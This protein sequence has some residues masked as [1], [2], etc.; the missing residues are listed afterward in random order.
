MH[1]FSIFFKKFNKLPFI[2]SRLD[3]KHTVAT[4]RENFRK[5]WK[6]FTKKLRICIILAYYSKNLTNPALI[7]CAFG[8]KR[9]LIGIFRKFSKNLKNFHPKLQ[10]CIILA[11]F[12]INL[13]N[14]A[15]IYCTFWR[16]RHFIGTFEKIFDNFENLSSEN[17]K[18]CIILAC[19]SKK[20]ANYAFILCAFGRKTQI[21][22]KFWKFFGISTQTPPGALPLDP[23]R[24]A[25]SALQPLSGVPSEPLP[26]DS[27][28]PKSSS[29]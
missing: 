10:K 11:Y 24:G 4:F 18:K 29:R 23:G 17:C 25:A 3:E 6:I 14:H 8:R 19:F 20:L 12:Q 7:L 13:K 16:Q 15:L 26:L 5:I 27:P 21:V 1:Y 22:G 2:F 28:E 9:Q